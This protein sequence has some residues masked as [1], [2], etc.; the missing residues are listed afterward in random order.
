MSY[1]AKW[2]FLSCAGCAAC[3]LFCKLA[4]HAFCVPKNLVYYSVC[5]GNCLFLSDE[6]PSII[7]SSILRLFFAWG[8]LCAPCFMPNFFLCFHKTRFVI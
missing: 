8:V 4:Q 6:L 5:L 3:V 1:C 2:L 7:F